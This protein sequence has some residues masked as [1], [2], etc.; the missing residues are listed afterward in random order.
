MGPL[1]NVY[2]SHAFNKM[3]IYITNGLLKGVF[4]FVVQLITIFFRGL[5]H[6]I[7]SLIQLGT[8]SRYQGWQGKHKSKVDI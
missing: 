3:M 5:P 4:A 2:Y 7:D 8:N 1:S 6:S